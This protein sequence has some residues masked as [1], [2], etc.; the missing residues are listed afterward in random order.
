MLVCVNTRR[1]TSPRL[2]QI[3]NLTFNGVMIKGL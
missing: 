1:L 3:N 2:R